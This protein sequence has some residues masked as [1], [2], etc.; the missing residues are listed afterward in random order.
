MELPEIPVGERDRVFME[1]RLDPVNLE[2]TA[3]PDIEVPII[4]NDP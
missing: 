4:L 2:M 3:E 1:T